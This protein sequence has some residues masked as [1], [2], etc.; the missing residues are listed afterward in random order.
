MKITIEEMFMNG[1]DEH[2]KGHLE[3]AK[4][5]YIDIIR[6][7]PK[8]HNANNNLG[9]ISLASF[10]SELSLHYFEKAIKGNSSIEQYFF[11]YIN[12][13]INLGKIDKARKTLKDCEGNNFD[14]KTINYLYT[15]CL[16]PIE[17]LR[18][19]KLYKANNQHYSEFLKILHK[20]KI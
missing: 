12:A 19:G 15:R 10:K 11:N 2:K 3:K 8:H 14:Q 5:I 17:C 9:L 18:S 7:N 4:K 1:V 13:L 6:L 16:N 20:K